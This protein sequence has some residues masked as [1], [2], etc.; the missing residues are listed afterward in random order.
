MIVIISNSID[1]STDIVCEHLQNEAIPFHRINIDSPYQKGNEVYYSLINRRDLIVW[2]RTIFYPTWKIGWQPEEYNL[3][4]SLI[5]EYIYSFILI[6]LQNAR[7]TLGFHINKGYF[8]N[9][10]T[11]LDVAKKAGLP[12]PRSYYVYE[13]KE[14][15]R[16]KCEHAIITK[17][18][19]EVFTIYGEKTK[20]K[21]LTA[22]LSDKDI[23]EFD[24]VF[25][26]SFIQEKIDKKFDIKLL[27]IDGEMFCIAID[28]KQG[29]KKDSSV[30]FREF[31]EEQLTYFSLDLSISM[32]RK[33]R[34]YMLMIESNFGV[35]DF[36]MDREEQIYFLEYNPYGIFHSIST[37]SNIHFEKT[38]SRWLKD[39]VTQMRS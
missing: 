25:G 5:L 9:K 2:V 28:V 37:K 20:F 10:L 34:Q 22:E 6:L 12:I 16:I 11:S 36:I 1:S 15:Q 23:D 38:V 18:F 3:V 27:Y 33:V 24:D 29:F 7:I 13:K 17:G 26:L 4:K 35:L 14:L 30:D 21:S 39:K 31:S 19:S 8:F 32:Q